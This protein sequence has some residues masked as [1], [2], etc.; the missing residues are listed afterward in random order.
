MSVTLSIYKILECLLETD[1]FDSIFQLGIANEELYASLQEIKEAVQNENILQAPP[2]LTMVGPQT[3][4]LEETIYGDSKQITLE[5]TERC[6]FR[7]NYCIYSEGYESFREFGNKDM[8][9]D[10]AKKL[11]MI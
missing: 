6:D 3:H 11:L 4:S 5:I 2:V 9:F 8:S 10:A 1:T 7:C